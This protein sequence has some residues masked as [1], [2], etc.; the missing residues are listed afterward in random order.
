MMQ[1]PPALTGSPNPGSMPLNQKSGNPGQAANA[2]AQIREALQLLQHALTSVPVGTE[3]YESVLKCISTL[4][5]NFPAAEAS[6][7]IQKTASLANAQQTQQQQPMVNLMRA[8]AGQG[9]SGMGGEVEHQ[10]AA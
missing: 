9:A 2:T 7:G 10:Q 6:P 3:A 5:K 4:S 8:M 1:L